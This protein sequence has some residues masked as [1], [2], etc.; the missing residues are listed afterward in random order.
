MRRH[1]VL[2]LLTALVIGVLTA[3]CGDAADTSGD[4]ASSSSATPA[5]LDRFYGQ[6]LS[7]GDC[8]PFASTA[9]ERPYYVA[10]F[11]CARM[12]VP[13][14]YS[15]P[16]GRTASIGVMRLPAKGDR[17]GSLVVNPGGPGGSG[18]TQA[19]LASI[20]LKNTDIPK[21]FDVVGFD[22]RG[23]GASTPAIHCFTDA[24]RDRG[25]DRVTA[26]G[27]AGP[28]T[29]DYTRN[30]VQECANR[31][32]G[33]DALAAVGTRDVARDMDVLRAV[34]GEQKLTFA[35][36]S[37][38]TRLGAVYAEMFPRNL[39]AMVLDGA[40]D[41]G[42]GTAERRI[43]LHRGFQRSFD[44]MAASCAKQADCPLGTDPGRSTEEFQK[45]TRPL[46]TN[47]VPAGG[48]RNL[49]FNQAT[50]GVVNGLYYS[51]QWPAIIAAIAQV[52]N[53]HRGEK[54]IALNDALAVRG[55]DG[56]WNNQ[57]D[58]NY[59]INCNDE[60][61]RTPEQEADLRSAVFETS[62]FLDPGQPVDGVSRDGC[63]AWPVAPS[64]NIPYAQDI[65]KSVLPQT[66]VIS[67]TG[68]P[69]T[70][71][72]SGKQL[73]QDLGAKMLTVNG[74]RHTVA[75]AGLNP[76]VNGMFADY[77]INL[78]LPADGASCTL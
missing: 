46:L 44:L 26:L 37:Y 31:S 34:L 58:A 19:A 12:T 69:V 38:G 24:Q 20:G 59:A 42:L 22:P 54:L 14:A 15:R 52:K 48:G 70:P 40:I 49:G 3:G 36:Q 1:P 56:V 76:C 23:V 29:A 9:V 6:S 67:V 4:A 39:R 45:I 64:L 7:W 51:E 17:I 5:A 50:G 74:E 73:A 16:E 65:D 25:D 75:Q 43:I 13:L 66:M 8:R 77:L 2:I 53:E 63:E 28:W 11:Q 71:Y 21:R 30:L 18:M 61:R 57:S 27:S 41:P 32:G 62:P 72:D 10:P 47:P 78:K 68:D 60:Q 55:P 35:G 33:R